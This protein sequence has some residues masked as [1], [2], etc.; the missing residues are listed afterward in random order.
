LEIVVWAGGLVGF[1]GLLKCSVFVFG[2]LV[3]YGLLYGYELRFGFDW[4]VFYW[5]F[6]AGGFFVFGEV[7]GFVY[8]LGSGISRRDAKISL[9]C[10]ER[11]FSLGGLQDFCGLCF[12]VRFAK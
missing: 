10:F 3:V 2:F 1:K 4:A 11:L 9:V 7:A 8:C 6:Y 12:G 5:N